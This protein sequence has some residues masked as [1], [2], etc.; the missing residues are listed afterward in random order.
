[1]STDREYHERIGRAT[2]YLRDCGWRPGDRLS[3]WSAACVAAGF[4]DKDTGLVLSDEAGETIGAALKADRRRARIASEANG[5][6]PEAP[7]D[8]VNDQ[9]QRAHWHMITLQESTE[10]LT[11]IETI[12]FATDTPAPMLS[13]SRMDGFRAL[14]GMESAPIVV[15]YVYCGLMTA[16]E[17]GA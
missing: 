4:A 3:L 13:A 1:M 15:S 14:A 9:P 17:M 2:K 10:R 6:E 11:R 12:R 5:A 8:Y 7:A 16:E